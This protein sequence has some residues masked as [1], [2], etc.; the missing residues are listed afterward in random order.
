[1]QTS[2]PIPPAWRWRLAIGLVVAL[3]FCLWLITFVYHRAAKANFE[4]HVAELAAKGES[5]EVDD[6]RPPPIENPEEDVGAAPVFAEFLE[7]CRANP[8]ADAGDDPVWGKLDIALVPGYSSDHIRRE[9]NHVRLLTRSPLS[10][11]FDPPAEEAA[12]RAILAYCEANAATLDEI[13]EALSRPNADFQVAYGDITAIN[14][15][16]G[17]FTA[18]C[19][20][21][22]LQGRAALLLGRTDLA[23]SNALALLRFSR[24]FGS[25]SNLLF[26][27]IGNAINHFAITLIHEG[28]AT[29]KWTDEDLKDLAAELESRWME[30]AFLRA[31]R[32]DRAVVMS[33]LDGF[34]RN[35][36]AWTGETRWIRPLLQ[37]PDLRKAF[38][39]D[40]GAFYCRVLD[41]TLLTNSRGDSLTIHI[42]TPFLPLPELPSAGS[43]VGEKF[44]FRVKF[45]RRGFSDSMLSAYASSRVATL[46]NQVFQD[47]A[48]ITIA[49][50][51]NQRERGVFPATL[52]SLTLPRGAPLPL[53]PF[54]GVNYLYRR[55]GENDYLLYSP[56]PN[57]LDEGGLI[58]H[59]RNDGDWVWRLHLPED[60]DYD[61]YR[62][63]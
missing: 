63:Q 45:F 30:A 21:L 39:Y 14:P 46:R 47:H 58:R 57:G 60:F 19:N 10:Q 51:L 15:E 43:S 2:F 61:A 23:R 59:D 35:P 52:D 17:V 16:I 6:L 38:F 50:A 44:R 1:M 24:H 13:R 49:L 25:H 36:A 42:A 32:M 12:A 4:A 22:H 9:E 54:T 18:T 56:G 8:K 53:D 11:G 20:L 37:V 7:R 33:T 26:G 62:G 27:A 28:L 40:N 55:E 41:E 48:L 3:V 34:S 29:R 5:L 31:V